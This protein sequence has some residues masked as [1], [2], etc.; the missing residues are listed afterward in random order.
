MDG[1]PAY[2][3]EKINMF[4]IDGV[5]FFKHAFEGDEIYQELADYYNKYEYRFEVPPADVAE[6]RMFLAE[7]DYWLVTRSEYDEFVVLVEQGTSHPDDIVRKAV[8]RTMLDGYNC[9]LLP[10]TVVVDEAI[11]AGATPLS[12]T[13]FDNPFTPEPEQT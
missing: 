12:A 3:H 6:I 7:Y 13:D 1:R 9:F 2:S 10:T 5:Y 4:E 8:T 11:D